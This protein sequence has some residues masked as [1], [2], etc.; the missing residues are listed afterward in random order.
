MESWGTA[1]GLY[2]GRPF[3]ASC[4][5]IKEQ[6]DSRSIL[7]HRNDR[8]VGQWYWKDDKLLQGSRVQEPVFEEYQ[9]FRVI[10]R[11]GIFNEDYLRELGLNE[12][13]IKVV[14]YVKE[15]GE[16][17][18]KKYQEICEVKERLATM[19]LKDI[20]EKGIFEKVGS[21]GRG[22]HYIINPSFK[23]Q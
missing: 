17:T 9:G 3:Q 8:A 15:N 12:R 6:R 16:I 21:R 22:T 11:K 4:L 1:S 13:Q 18:N 20:V 5:E 10:F 7:W 14:F 19:E 2:N 23:P